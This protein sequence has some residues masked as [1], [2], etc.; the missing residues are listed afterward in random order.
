MVDKTLNRR[1]ATMSD[2]YEQ[3]NVKE[4]Y[5]AQDIVFT[6]VG[7]VC[8]ATAAVLFARFFTGFAGI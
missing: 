8:T 3:K 4:L 1:S 7:I 5:R 2:H 6:L